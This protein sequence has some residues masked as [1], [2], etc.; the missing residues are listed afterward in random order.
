MKIKLKEMKTIISL[1]KQEIKQKDI[2]KT[3]ISLEKSEILDSIEG[4]NFEKKKFVKFIL[5]FLIN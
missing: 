5:E 2:L 1:L 3:N 4:K